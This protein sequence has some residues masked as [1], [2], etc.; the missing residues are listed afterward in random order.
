MLKPQRVRDRVIDE[1][2]VTQ[3]EEFT[4]DAEVRRQVT[5]S[6]NTAIRTRTVSF[7][8]SF[9]VPILSLPYLHSGPFPIPALAI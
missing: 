6:M 8:P 7:P 1:R 4:K 3:S 2:G 5:E 9:P